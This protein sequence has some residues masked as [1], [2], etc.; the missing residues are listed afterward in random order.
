MAVGVRETVVI[1]SHQV[2]LEP[3]DLMLLSTDGLHGVIQEASI[4]GTLASDT[5]LAE[6]TARLIQIARS[7]GGPDNITAVL[8]RPGIQEPAGRS[9]QTDLTTR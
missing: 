6:K 8:V 2:R 3:G 4:A 9:Q 7:Q 5:T 1:R